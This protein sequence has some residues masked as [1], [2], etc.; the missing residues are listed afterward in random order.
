MRNEWL[1]RTDECGGS[2]VAQIAKNGRMDLA[3]VLMMLEVAD[4]ANRVGTLPAMH[5]AAYWNYGDAIQDLLEEGVDPSVPN[6]AG[7]TPLHL[8]VRYGNRE[9]AMALI[10]SGMETGI[11]DSLGMTALHWA[12]LKGFD[13]LAKALVVSGSDP[14]ALEWVAGGL[15]PV[16]LARMM[17]HED[18]AD[19][20]QGGIDAC[21]A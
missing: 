8:A 17:G 9:A 2:P 13:D 21:L 4:E 20:L 15:S 6:D 18:L 3:N 12:A 16:K 1:C 11:P 19:A 10:N 14:F 7:E 5:R